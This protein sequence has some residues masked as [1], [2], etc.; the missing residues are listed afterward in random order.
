M[1]QDTTTKTYSILGVN[2]I[3]AEVPLTAEAYD[4]YAG[5]IG[6]CLDVALGYQ[7]P[8]SFHSKVRTAILAALKVAGHEPAEGET[9]EKFTTR[10]LDSKA[11][12][13]DAYQVLG[14]TAAASVNSLACLAGAERATIG[15]EWLEKA[16]AAQAVWESGARSFADSLAKWQKADSS[17]NVAYPSD[18]EAVARAMRAYSTALAN[19]NF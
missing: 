9:Q 4:K 12:D 8:R 3:V 2:G 16:Q 6:A 17:I 18:S 15:K 14:R 19:D 7:M 13:A 10:L 1:S 5:R 11:I